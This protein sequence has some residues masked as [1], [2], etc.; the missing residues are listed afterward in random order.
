LIAAETL[1]TS[2]DIES[3]PLMA[4]AL[5]VTMVKVGDASTVTIELERA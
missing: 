1:A 5:G 3:Q 4:A 2:L